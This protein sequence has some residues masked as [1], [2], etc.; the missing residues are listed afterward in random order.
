MNNHN[1]KAKPIA[2]LVPN[3]TNHSCGECDF[4]MFDGCD[5]PTNKEICFAMDYKQH[6]ERVNQYETAVQRSNVEQR[7]EGGSNL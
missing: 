5:H 7:G 3:K 4:N 6:Y 2:V 1:C